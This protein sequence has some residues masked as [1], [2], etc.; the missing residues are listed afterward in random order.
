[1]DGVL[2]FH[3]GLT[4]RVLARDARK[5]PDRPEPRLQRTRRQWEQAAQA[6]SAAEEAE[7]FQAVGARCRETLL[8]L[9]HAIGTSAIIPE[10]DEPPKAS[11]FIHWSVHIANAAAPGPS[12]AALRGYLKSAAKETWQY[13][14]WLTHAKNAVRF[15]GDIAVETVGHYLS[16]TE[17][18]IERAERA[19][20]DH[21]P[22]CGSYRVAG[23][24]SFDLDAATVTRRRLCEACGWDEEYEPEPLGPP[25]TLRSPPEG[26]CLPSSEL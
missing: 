9:A 5:A 23:D 18:A 24:Q 4:A 11:D 21:C 13:V 2:S 6:Q 7:D 16:L 20:P 22:S 25:P 26:E 1:M 12:S 8:S 15:D 14:N 10:G 19:G 3:I 17:Q